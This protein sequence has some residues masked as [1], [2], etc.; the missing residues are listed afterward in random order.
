[1]IQK[2]RD[3][4]QHYS[5]MLI[6]W[7]IIWILGYYSILRF[8]FSHPYSDYYSEKNLVNV[9]PH[10]LRIALSQWKSS[11]TIVDV[12]SQ[13]EY[14]EWHI[15]TA[16]NVPAYKNRYESDYE[17][18]ERIINDFRHMQKAYPKRDTVIYCYSAACMTAIK[19]G[20]M[21]AK[22]WIYVKHL[23]IGRNERKYHRTLWNH[24]HERGT[25]SPD[26]RIHIWPDPWVVSWSD[27]KNTV[28]PINNNL[29]C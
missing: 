2:T 19:V 7:I 13:E 14:N 9:S 21:L 10:G 5:F 22:E 12:R 23:N 20:E 1:M 4:L 27:T 6:V 25:S 29:W 28:C 24:E 8:S 26:D 11:Y 17:N 15:I 18:T 16:L 3:F